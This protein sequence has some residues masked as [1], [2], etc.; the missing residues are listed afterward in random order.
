MINGI[1]SA[2]F[3]LSTVLIFNACATI[4]YK[5]INYGTSKCNPY[6]GLIAVEVVAN[7]TSVFCKNGYIFSTDREIK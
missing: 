4:N 3:I 6:G 5:Q 2:V 7:S 1:I